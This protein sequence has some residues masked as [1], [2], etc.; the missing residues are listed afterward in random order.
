MPLAVKSESED[1][2]SRNCIY[3]KLF[4]LSTNKQKKFKKHF[5][6]NVKTNRSE[7]DAFSGSYVIGFSQK[8]SFTFY[9]LKKHFEFKSSRAEFKMKLRWIS[10]LMVF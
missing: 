8:K 7:K 3:A 2:Y 5:L 10:V 9:P 4:F 1:F 6:S